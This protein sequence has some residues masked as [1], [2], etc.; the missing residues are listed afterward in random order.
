MSGLVRASPVL[1]LLGWPW[2]QPPMG[3][4]SIWGVV[5]I[6]LL[7]GQEGVVLPPRGSP[8]PRASARM[9]EAV[10]HAPARMRIQKVDL[11]SVLGRRRDR[12]P[13]AHLSLRAD[14][15]SHPSATVCR[16]AR[17]NFG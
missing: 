15:S 11:R 9:P 4:L 2:R 14:P 17:A 6:P 7:L 5:Q 16:K 12:P 8:H 3:R 1:T 10:D 13:H